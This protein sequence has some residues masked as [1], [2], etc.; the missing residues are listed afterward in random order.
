VTEKEFSQPVIQPKSNNLVSDFELP[1]GQKGELPGGFTGINSS[2]V[3][4]STTSGAVVGV[5]R[6]TYLVAD[7][8]EH[9]LAPKGQVRSRIIF[10]N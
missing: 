2:S 9:D 3:I 6:P 4:G 5:V 10:I 8:S 7:F 1:Q